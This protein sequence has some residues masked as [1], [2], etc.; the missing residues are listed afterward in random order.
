MNNQ[1]KIISWLGLLGM[2]FFAILYKITSY[3][4]NEKQSMA[5]W[6]IGNLALILF[7]TILIFLVITIIVTLLSIY[8][9]K[10]PRFLL[11][12]DIFLLALFYRP[13]VFIAKIF[14]F[15]K[16]EVRD[17]YILMNN[18][19]ILTGKY[20]LKA[21]EIMILTPHCIQLNTCKHKVTGEISNCV[22]CGGCQIMNLLQ[23]KEDYKI[24]VYVATGG[25]L[26]RRIIMEKK[27]KAIIAVACQRDLMSGIKDVSKIPVYGV[28]NERPNGPCFNT[29]INEASVR[30]AVEFFLRGGI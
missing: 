3:L 17:I 14:G 10:L 20:K 28:L 9:K 5:I 26:A 6:A 13:L 23:I 21:E 7:M 30:E 19:Y 24:Q 8:D 2:A 11:A 22:K 29:R 4:W 25:T 15:S 18:K 16:D 27:P 12:L 1:V